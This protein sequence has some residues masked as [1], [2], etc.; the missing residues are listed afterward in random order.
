LYT[1]SSSGETEVKF[2]EQD[3]EYNIVCAYDS[4][5]TTWV[6][7]SFPSSQIVFMRLNVEYGWAGIDTDESSL[8]T[9]KWVPNYP[10]FMTPAAAP[11]PGPVV[12]NFVFVSPSIMRLTPVQVDNVTID[13]D[14]WKPVKYLFSL[15]D[16]ALR[17]IETRT[18]IYNSYY[19]AAGS[20]LDSIDFSVASQYQNSTLS[21]KGEVQ[22]AFGDETPIMSSATYSAEVY[23]P[24]L[25]VIK[26]V[27]MT[28]KEKTFKLSV[29]V[30]AG[31]TTNTAACQV[32]ALV[33]YQIEGTS[34]FSVT[35]EYNASTKLFESGTLDKQS[36][37]SIYTAAIVGYVVVV[38][39]AGAVFAA[40]P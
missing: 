36:D 2:A 9:S 13:G 37:P 12:S 21:V 17:V 33:P 27:K 11:V 31:N 29:N 25:A 24:T 23:C 20:D 3:D 4:S 6:Q 8:I 22:Y 19:P 26:S 1:I 10:A 7:K 40:F 30:S 5:G 34:Y 18:V 15:L 14:G 16:S 32:T 28:E 38:N 35:L 39:G